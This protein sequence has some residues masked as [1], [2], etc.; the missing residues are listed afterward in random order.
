VDFYWPAE[1]LIV[2][3]DGYGFHGHRGAF[4]Q[5]R[6]KGLALTAAGERVVRVTWRQVAHD[7]LWLAPTLAQAL[8]K[9]S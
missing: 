3:V 5:D 1:R 9:G 2:E 8:A 7:S 4:E 6:R